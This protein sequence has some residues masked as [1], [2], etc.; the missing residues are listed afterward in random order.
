MDLELADGSEA[1]SN[2]KM[3]LK[4]Y[5]DSNTSHLTGF[6]R[7]EPFPPKPVKWLVLDNSPRSAPG[8]IV[9]E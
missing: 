3:I 6:V 1:F 2:P 7:P 5:S 4:V 8:L 9:L